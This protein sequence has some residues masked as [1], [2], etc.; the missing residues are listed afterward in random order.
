MRA[1]YR[2]SSRLSETSPRRRTLSFALAI[3]LELLLILALLGLGGKRPDRPSLGK[4]VLGITF[5]PNEAASPTPTR[6]RRQRPASSRADSRS[7]PRPLPPKIKLPTPPADHSL[8]M[9]IVT[10]DVYAAADIAKLGTRGVPSPAGEGRD[11][12]L[13]EGDGDSAVVG[14]GPD[15]KPLYNAEWVRRPTDRELG[16]YLPPNPP[17]VGWG[18]V[19]CKTIAHYHVEDCVELGNSPPGSHLAG[20]VRQAAWQFLVRPSRVGGK[21]LTGTWVRIRIDYTQEAERK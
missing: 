4:G 9:L 16:A 19:A 21:E 1:T 3:A 11:A 14:T 20:A 12:Q 7:A 15:G 10:R 6:T 5:L 13:A 17:P 8:P 18:L 2:L